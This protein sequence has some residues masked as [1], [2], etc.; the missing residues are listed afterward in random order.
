MPSICAIRSCAG[1]SGF[2]V[3]ADDATLLAP[4]GVLDPPGER[5]IVHFGDAGHHDPG[6]LAC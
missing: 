2:E 3:D 5:Q 1:V 6:S 4:A